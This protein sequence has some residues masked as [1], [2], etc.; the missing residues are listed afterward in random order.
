MP[1]CENCDNHVSEKFA[2]VFGE[3]NGE[4]HACPNC[5]AQAGIAETSRDRARLS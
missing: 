4:V 5:S 1:S 3:R 2:R